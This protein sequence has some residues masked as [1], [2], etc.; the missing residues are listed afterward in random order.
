MSRMRWAS[1]SLLGLLVGCGGS[2]D[3]ADSLADEAGPAGESGSTSAGTAGEA[4]TVEGSTSA[5]ETAS[6]VDTSAEGSTS[7]DET[8]SSADT[9]STFTPS[10]DG[11]D[12]PPMDGPS[13]HDTATEADGVVETDTGSVGGECMTACDCMQGLG[14]AESLECAPVPDNAY[15]CDK[16]GCPSDEPCQFIDGSFGICP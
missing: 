1:L 11:M 13:T 4:G 10:T 14:C 6:S 16:P 9:S 8:A 5:D 7:A 15:C 2:D 3:F 12:S